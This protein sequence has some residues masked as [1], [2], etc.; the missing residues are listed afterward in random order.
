M[1]LLS[2]VLLALLASSQAFGQ[3]YTIS[4]FAGGGLPVNIPGTSASLRS[5]SSVAVDKAGNVYFTDQ[6]NIV[7][8]L[9]AVTAVLTLA[10]GNGTPG[11]SGDNGP[12]TSAQLNAPSGVAVDTFGNLYIADSFNSRIRK[13]ANGVIA[14]V[15]GGGTRYPVDNGPA[16]SAYLGGN[17]HGVAVDA[18]GNLYIAG[19]GDE[20]IYKVSNGVITTVAGNGTP[21]FSGDNGPAT[22]AQVSVPHGVAVDSAGNLYVADTDNGR[23][24]KVS[25]GVITTVAGGGT[26]YPGDNGPATSGQLLLPSTV[27]VD[28]SGNLFIAEG[29]RIRK[30]SNGVITTVAGGGTSYPGDNGPATSALLNGP[31]GVAVDLT[32]NLYIADNYTN[33]IRKVSTGVISTVAGGGTNPY[34]DNGPSTSAQFDNPSGVAV[35]STGNL[36]IADNGSSRVRKVSNG[37]ITTVAGGGTSYPGDNGPA[38]SASFVRG[39]PQGVAVDSAGTLYIAGSA[40]ERVLKVSNGTI[41]TVAGNGTAGFNGDNRPATSAELN[42][43]MGVAVDSAGALYIADYVN[44]RVRT[45]SNGVITTAAEPGRTAS[46]A[47]TARPPAPR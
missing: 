38:T 32:G 42:N 37:V 25:N 36:Y 45:V 8:R 11:F 22:D 23:I 1:R 28:A 19:S 20:R 27:V 10:A 33:S 41:A 7:L 9:D 15:A 29:F 21:G 44:N 12:A 43:P 40:G 26:S 14:T 39:E 24:R 31:A 18:A 30:V 2:A 16:T 34:G 35:D 3:T 47:T 4:T 17:P 6:R 13:V 46:A 5:P